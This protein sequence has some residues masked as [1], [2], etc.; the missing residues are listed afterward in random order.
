VK[1]R[2]WAHAI[3]LFQALVVAR[4]PASPEQKQLATVWTLAGQ[5]EEA[6]KAWAAYADAITDEKERSDALAESQRLHGAPDPFADKIEI[7]AMTAEAKQ[8]FSLGRA[9]FAKKQYGDALVYFHMGYALA[10]ELPGFLRELGS[11]YDKLGESERKKEFYKRYLVQRPFGANADVVRSELAKEKDSLG[12]LIVSASLP[13]TELWIN[14]QKIPGKLP[15]AG[16]LVAP[17]DYK[18]LCFNPKYEMAMFQ[19]ATVEAGKPTGLTFTWAIVVNHLDHPLGRI[20]VESA[21]SPGVM[22]DLGITSPEVGV[23]VPLDGHPLKMILKDDSGVR[24]VER[25]VQI[26][27]GQRLIVQW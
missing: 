21:T 12:T 16:L 22:M 23:T 20:A 27:P 24:T 19:Y 13:C 9:A 2:D 25:S 4:G 14:R 17:G 1:A 3:P 26:E 11:T 6:S 10:P 15:A 8:A 18:G 7:T 5:N